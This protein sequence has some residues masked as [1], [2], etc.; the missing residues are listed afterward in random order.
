MKTIRINNSNRPYDIVREINEEDLLNRPYDIV[1][2]INEADLKTKRLGGKK[3]RILV[4]PEGIEELGYG[5]CTEATSVQ[6]AVLPEGLERIAES[7]FYDTLVERVNFPSTI[8]DVDIS[9]FSYCYNLKEIEFAGRR[10]KIKADRREN[11]QD[12][13][14]VE[15]GALGLISSDSGN[16]MMMDPKTQLCYYYDLYMNK[17]TGSFDKDQ[18]DMIK[19]DFFVRVAKEQEQREAEAKQNALREQAYKDYERVLKATGVVD[20][21]KFKK[22]VSYL[23]KEDAKKELIAQTVEEERQDARLEQSGLSAEERKNALRDSGNCSLRI[24]VLKRHIRAMDREEQKQA[25]SGAED[26]NSTSKKKTIDDYIFEEST[27]LFGFGV[28]AIEA[29]KRYD[30]ALANGELDHGAFNRF[31]EMLSKKDAE[32]RLESVN[33]MIEVEDKSSEAYALLCDEKTALQERIETIDAVSKENKTINL[34]RSLETESGFKEREDISA[35]FKAEGYTHDHELFMNS[36]QSMSCNSL[37]SH[38]VRVGLDI[39]E[40]NKNGFQTD[41]KSELEFQNKQIELS[42]ELVQINSC[43]EKLGITQQIR[44]RIL[45]FDH[46]VRTKNRLEEGGL[47]EQEEAKQQEDCDRW[48]QNHAKFKALAKAQARKEHVFEIEELSDYEFAVVRYPAG[49]EVSRGVIVSKPEN[50]YNIT[51]AGNFERATLDSERASLGLIMQGGEGSLLFDIYNHTYLASKQD[52]KFTYMN[53]SR[54]SKREK[55]A[56]RLLGVAHVNECKRLLPSLSTE[57]QRAG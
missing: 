46:F 54:V 52:G 24:S 12:R 55:P 26:A 41:R 16:V 44:D 4:V 8:K 36:V 10:F 13:I 37:L 38:F 7:A 6:I 15:N 57:T 5:A 40:L 32:Q 51:F 45:T 39:K 53:I 35:G 17:R 23:S 9:A 31:V 28:G 34:I 27:R 19:M 50:A 25:T 20:Y 21:E 3:Y 11:K 18:L 33:E 43:L 29:Q 56:V 14:F 48:A 30:E 2:G 47:T 49:G 42:I 1:I 22:Y